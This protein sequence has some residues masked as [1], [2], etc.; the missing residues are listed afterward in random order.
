M[1]FAKVRNRLLFCSF[2][3]IPFWILATPIAAQTPEL[4]TTKQ[5]AGPV[6]TIKSSGAEG[7]KYGFEGGRVL[8]LN[9]SYPLPG[10]FMVS[11][12]LQNTS[13]PMLIA[14]YAASNA[15]IAPS[16][17][18]NLAACGTRTVCASTASVP[19][20]QPGTM[21]EPRKTQLDIRLSKTLK[22]GRRLSVQGKFDAYNVLNSSWV[23]SV[24][25][26]YG[27]QWLRPLTIINGR[28]FQVSTS[29]NF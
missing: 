8:K 24:T 1:K 26:A 27:P 2:F 25:A 10:N 14:S 28:L 3:Y 6:L 12:I 18:R 20:I 13:G 5:F 21:Y 11:G 7:N 4:V 17:G 16:L 19:L 15:E 23:Q 29:I 22:V 9:G